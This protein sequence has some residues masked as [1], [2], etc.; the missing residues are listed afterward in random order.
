MSHQQASGDHFKGVI[1][2]ISIFKDLDPKR[3][4]T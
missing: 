1:E 4:D 2:F 3:Y